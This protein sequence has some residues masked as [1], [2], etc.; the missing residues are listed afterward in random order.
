MQHPSRCLP[1]ANSNSSYN[2]FKSDGSDPCLS[3]DYQLRFTVLDPDNSEI[4]DKDVDATAFDCSDVGKQ[5]ALLH[6]Q[7]VEYFLIV[8]IHHFHQ[9][10]DLYLC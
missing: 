7:Y 9:Q 8:Q 10:R 4:H 5:D 6:H 2:V 1:S 3:S